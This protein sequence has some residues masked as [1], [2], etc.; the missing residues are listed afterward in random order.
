MDRS[1]D[2]PAGVRQV[3]LLLICS[4]TPVLGLLLLAPA[5]PQLARQFANV[6]G[7]AVLVPMLLTT[8]ALVIAL[9]APFIGWLTDRIGRRRLLL[10]A[11]GLYG[12]AGPLP[13]VL[14]DL[15]L[16]LVSRIAVGCAEAA[17]LT[18]ATTLVGDYFA[19]A[20]RDRVL[21]LTS[22]VTSV[23]AILVTFIGGVLSQH[24]WHVAFTGYAVALL[25]IPFA[26]AF[27]W[28]PR[29]IAAPIPGTA[30]TA[31][32]VA[33]PAR[34]LASRLAVICGLTVF[35]T[36]GFTVLPVFLPLLLDR[37]GLHQPF[38]IG[39]IQSGGFLIVCLS[40]LLFRRILGVNLTWL[41]LLSFAAF[42]CGFA[43]VA[44]A[45][46]I[47]QLMI[48]NIIAAVGAGFI[49]PTAMVWAMRLLTPRERARGAGLWNGSFFLGQFIGPPLIAILAA[50]NG[51]LPHAIGIA[52]V[53]FGA[54]SLLWLA[55][56][57]VLL[58]R[59]QRGDAVIEAE[60]LPA[61]H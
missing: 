60:T 58:H 9:V 52:A 6:P 18:C 47:A 2:A 4:C 41:M 39:A 13:A 38:M 48:G 34:G 37:L 57:P 16:I 27:I 49:L 8:P 14:D 56:T 54:A 45:N 33:G 1:I 23:C 32:G 42:G 51:G 28:E 11:L 46:S 59:A 61:I 44:T 15:H 55:L 36:I 3:T 53:T 50:A 22:L 43:V 29:R 20:A 17:I 7:S 31:S 25:L 30:T 24:S 10:C 35:G 21:A 19:G 26:A 40:S 5:L 12:I